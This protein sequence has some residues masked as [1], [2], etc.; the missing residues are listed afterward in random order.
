M[1]QV[2]ERTV[3]KVPP[4]DDPKLQPGEEVFFCEDLG[5]LIDVI[6]GVIA[7]VRTDSVCQ[8]S[9]F[10]LIGSDR[11][12]LP[13]LVQHDF[14]W[15]EPD[16]SVTEYSHVPALGLIVEA[17]VKT[18]CIMCATMLPVYR[19]GAAALHGQQ[20]WPTMVKFG[21]WFC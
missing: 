2:L 14:D 8:F 17:C 18:R 21:S 1:E 5:C 11:R 19:D 10:N 3:T 16:G 15:L 4:S 7:A 6:D 13:P 12:A 9:G 20:P